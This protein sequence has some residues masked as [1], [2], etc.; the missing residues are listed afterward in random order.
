MSSGPKMTEASPS[1]AGR[2]GLAFAADLVP[3]EVFSHPMTTSR[4]SQT[5][6]EVI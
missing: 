1:G 6:L 2:S 4:C 5:P 3:V